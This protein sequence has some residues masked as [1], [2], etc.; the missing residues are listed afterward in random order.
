MMRTTLTIDDD[1]LHAARTLAAERGQSVGAVLSELARRG[2]KPAAPP[3][4]CRDAFPV[5]EVR[6]DAAV[7]GPEDV[8]Q[9]LDQE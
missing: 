6:E 4:G 3:G 8:S 7:F 1:V 5:F 9:A 2:L